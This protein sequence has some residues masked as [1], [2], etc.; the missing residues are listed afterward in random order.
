MDVD[1]EP[2]KAEDLTPITSKED[3][4]ELWFQFASGS[5]ERTVSKA[6]AIHVA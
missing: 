1:L 6:V 4:P 3:K 5:G 2:V